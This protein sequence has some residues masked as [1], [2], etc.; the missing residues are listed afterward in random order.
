MTLETAGL[1]LGVLLPNAQY[2]EASSCRGLTSCVVFWTLR[3][4]NFDGIVLRL[5]GIALE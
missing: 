4:A 5:G 2:I 1:R 3:R